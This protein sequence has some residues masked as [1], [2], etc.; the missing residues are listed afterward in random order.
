MNVSDPENCSGYFVCMGSSLYPRSCNPGET[1]HQ[2]ILQCLT[3]QE[4]CQESCVKNG[5]YKQHIVYATT[6]PVPVAVMST[7]MTSSI[8][9]QRSP[10]TLAPVVSTSSAVAMETTTST[11]VTGSD[12]TRSSSVT[13][14]SVTRAS[15]SQSVSAVSEPRRTTSN[16][17][18]TAGELHRL[19]V[20]PTDPSYT[21]YWP[22]TPCYV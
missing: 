17:Q 7:E 20:T 13:T 14:S 1:F 21:V 8:A 11:A 12:V 19:T 10:T 2:N 9:S 4:S 6:T 16:W 15:V 18:T 5:S 3:T 22:T